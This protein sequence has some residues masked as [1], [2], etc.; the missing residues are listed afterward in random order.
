MTIEIYHQII[1]YLNTS[2]PSRVRTPENIPFTD[3]GYMSDEKVPQ[4]DI[5]L[6]IGRAAAFLK[7]TEI[8][9]CAGQGWG[10][11]RELAA[12]RTELVQL[13][14]L[15]YYD[16]TQQPLPFICSYKL[17]MQK[18]SFTTQPTKLIYPLFPEIHRLFKADIDI[19]L[20]HNHIN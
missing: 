12:S 19:A 8:H 14:P 7:P 3:H 4:F 20:M 9:D 18:V 17:S 2:R 6:F 11:C 16:A 15:L 5:M 13:D 1:S 10:W